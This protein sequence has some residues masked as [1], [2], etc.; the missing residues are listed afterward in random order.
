MKSTVVVSWWLRLGLI[1]F[2]CASNPLSANI[3]SSLFASPSQALTSSAHK[4]ASSAELTKLSLPELKVLARSNENSSGEASLLVAQQQKSVSDVG[5]R[6]WIKQAVKKQYPPAILEYAHYQLSQNNAAESYQLLELATQFESTRIA[7]S[8]KLADVYMQNKK[9]T[10]ALKWYEFASLNGSEEAKSTLNLLNNQKL[11]RNQKVPLLLASNTTNLTSSDIS[12]IQNQ[13]KL[14]LQFV[15]DFPDAI[16]QSNQF[17]QQFKNHP[18]LSKLPVCFYQPQLIDSSLLKCQ[19]GEDDL[20]NCDATLFPSLTLPDDVGVLAVITRGGT[21]NLNNGIMYLEKH[22]TFK[23]FVHEFAHILGFRDEY[24]WAKRKQNEECTTSY[25]KVLGANL[26]WYPANVSKKLNMGLIDLPW[27]RFKQDNHYYPTSVCNDA[28]VAG[29]VLRIVEPVNFM[30]F[31]EK[32]IP[33]LYFDILEDRLLNK[34]HLSVPYLVNIAQGFKAKGNK[35]RYREWL[36][37]S[38]EFGFAQAQHIY[39]QELVDQSS[40]SEAVI[41]LTQAA[42][43]GVSASQVSL[44]HFYI[45][46]VRVKQNLEKAFYWYQQAANKGDP[47]AQYFVGKSYEYAWGVEQD[48]SQAFNWY[49]QSAIRENQLGAFHLG[50]LYHDG[51]GVVADV[52]KAK[53]W[54]K[55]AKL[56]G[57]K[58]ASERLELLAH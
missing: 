35:E 17:I 37:K 10:E 50:R 8:L 57:H 15:T 27:A 31:F 19:E 34:M 18:Q 4:N 40:F 33:P 48:L 45:E 12:S 29:Q 38:A 25:P 5:Y 49:E 47:F 42:V 30:R 56:Y 53:H 43:N 55:K 39:A 36:F 6:A 13:C 28:N 11:R 52:E 1:C 24:K 26:I 54:F 20:I 14:N 44:A 51:E 58:G 16:V 7:A 9:Q 41:W 22:D 46:G 23:V 21:A 2:L 32:D 3:L